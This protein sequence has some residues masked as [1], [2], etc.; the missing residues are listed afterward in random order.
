MSASPSLLLLGFFLAAV[1]PVHSVRA[2]P[3]NP[4]SLRYRLENLWN[5][6]DLMVRNE[7]ADRADLRRQE[8]QFALLE[9]YQR[10]PFEDD[11]PGLRRQLEASAKAHSLRIR[12][13]TL[14]SR[15]AGGRPLPA[16]LTT[17]RESF[18]LEDSQVAQE[19][20]VEISGSGNPARAELWTS[21]LEDSLLRLVRPD[22]KHGSPTVSK[23]PGGRWSFRGVAYRFRRIRFPQLR[24]RD[25]FTLL[26]SWAKAD[27]NA[28]AAR[29]PLLSD[30]ISRIREQIPKTREAYARRGA[31]LLNS[32]RMQ[33]YLKASNRAEA[34][35]R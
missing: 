19:L 3:A 30:Y 23:R 22:R 18:R 13:V 29:E 2:S 26:P 31:F 9:V 8:R 11:L 17:D 10:I 5:E 24:P 32:A 12:D 25:P 1:P 27:P 28:F 14:L 16:R 21:S 20:R 33:F 6:V 34:R 35:S 7:S 15:S 4:A